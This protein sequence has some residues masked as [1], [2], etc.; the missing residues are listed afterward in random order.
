MTESTPP[1]TDLSWLEALSL[2]HKLEKQL[3]YDVQNDIQRMRYKMTASKIELVSRKSIRLHQMR[4]L[5]NQTRRLAREEESVMGDFTGVKALIETGPQ[6]PTGID[7]DDFSATRAKLITLGGKLTDIR[8]KQQRLAG[9]VEE[10]QG[11][12]KE[13]VDMEQ[14]NE[15]E[16][17]E[18]NMESFKKESSALP[19]MPRLAPTLGTSYGLFNNAPY[20]PDSSRPASRMS[21]DSERGQF[22]ASPIP[23]DQK[24]RT[25]KLRVQVDSTDDEDLPSDAYLPSRRKKQLGGA[26]TGV[27]SRSH[28]TSESSDAES[29]D[30]YQVATFN[31]MTPAEAKEKAEADRKKAA[32]EEERI[33]KEVEDQLRKEAE[34]E[35]RQKEEAARKKKEDDEKKKAAMEARQKAAAEKAAQLEAKKKEAEEKKKAEADAKR[36]AEQEKKKAEN[37]AKRKKEEEAKKK[38]DE[39]EARKKAEAEAKKAEVEAKRKATAE[40]K[41]AEEEAEKQ[42]KE[43]EE[44][45]KRQDDEEAK[46]KKEE[47]WAKKK[48][49]EADAIAKKKEDEAANQKKL[50]DEKKA[51]EAEKKAAADKLK[52]DAI[53]AEEAKVRKEALEAKKQAGEARANREAMEEKRRVEQEEKRRVE[54]EIEVENQRK[55]KELEARMKTEE[56]QRKIAPGSGRASKAEAEEALYDE[57]QQITSK[58]ELFS[59]ISDTSLKSGKKMRQRRKLKAEEEYEDSEEEVPAKKQSYK[60]RTASRDRASEVQSPKHED[61]EMVSGGSALSRSKSGEKARMEAVEPMDTST[62]GAAK[63]RPLS[64]EGPRTAKS[65]VAPQEE[66][67]EQRTTGRTRTVSREGPRA[68][69]ALEEPEEMIEERTATRTRTIS[70]EGPKSMQVVDEPDMFEQRTTARTRT[71]SREGPKTMQMVDEPMDTREQMQTSANVLQRNAS[72]DNVQARRAGF[73]SRTSSKEGKDTD[74]YTTASEDG[75]PIKKSVMKKSVSRQASG[76]TLD[77]PGPGG[78]RPPSRFSDMA[79]ENL[80]QLTWEDDEEDESMPS[81]A[82]MP[83]LQGAKSRTSSRERPASKDSTRPASRSI[84][85]LEPHE[86]AKIDALPRP[87]SRTIAQEEE[88][89]KIISESEKSRSRASSKSGGSRTSSRER[90]TTLDIPSAMSDMQATTAGKRTRTTSRERPKDLFPDFDEEEIKTEP[91]LSARGAKSRTASRERPPGAGVGRQGSFGEA[92]VT[93]GT[94]GRPRVQPLWPEDSSDSE[95]N[96]PQARSRTSSADR[97]K[98]VG[99]GRDDLLAED[100]AYGALSPGPGATGFRSY[101]DE[102]ELDTQVYGNQY[103]AVDTALPD[104]ASF[105]DA[106]ERFDDTEDEPPQMEP[107]FQSRSPMQDPYYQAQEPDPISQSLSSASGFSRDSLLLQDARSRTTSRDK[108]RQDQASIGSGR[109]HERVDQPQSYD[110]LQPEEPVS[111]R[112]ARSRTSSRDSRRYG[113][114]SQEEEQAQLRSASREGRPASYLAPEEPEVMRSRTASREGRQA[115]LAPEEST[116]ARS[117]TTSREGRYSRSEDQFQPA[118]E[119]MDY[120]YKYDEGQYT[121]EPEDV[122]SKSNKKVSFA[123]ADQKFHLRPDP[124]VKVLPGTKLFS[125]APSS[126]HEQPPDHPAKQA[127]LNLDNMPIPTLET[128][129]MPTEP[130]DPTSPKAF[131]KAMAKGVK[132]QPKPKEEK[133][134]SIIDSLLRRG[135]SSSSNQGSRNSSRQSSMDRAFSKQGGSSRSDYSAGSGEYEVV[136]FLYVLKLNYNLSFFRM[137]CLRLHQ[138][139][140]YSK[141]RSQKWLKKLILINYLQEAMQ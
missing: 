112:G 98:L 133:S 106:A 42:R 121:S 77:L 84:P 16:G 19:D 24:H 9:Q 37:E 100:D 17:Y 97:R 34:E 11:A 78:S 28:L 92:D 96:Q 115:Y 49:G 57:T 127:H 74:A 107:I 135:R 22:G 36:K 7:E 117:R 30:C 101:R 125:F 75:Y 23:E 14:L 25:I 21:M 65:P 104:D 41:K 54:E 123:E 6:V 83:G 66:M 129:P 20:T 94:R 8:R 116:T 89:L 2:L 43:E 51:A 91:R 71:V 46:R 13:L 44:A 3:T 58:E 126:T 119:T 139:P 99:G 79:S 105:H 72:G 90:P 103:E 5:L 86:Q 131:L 85:D 55:K 47:Q 87:G 10:L 38:K 59:A 108:L 137:L 18:F 122:V 136:L 76:D 64:R 141:R 32:E 45:K 113:Y 40:K 68:I 27:R 52:E 130:E 124:D 12:M 4:L 95:F 110:Y 35:E 128:V 120:Q 62:G 69:Q 132:G 63:S 102:M 1:P 80:D 53:A 50:E 93:A 60:S 109:S 70:R 140:P 138:F 61:L 15:P 82:P 114:V 67:V 111:T 81:L 56:A 118:L 88:V 33:K 31:R 48:Q 29:E 39:A 134:G 26:R 73:S